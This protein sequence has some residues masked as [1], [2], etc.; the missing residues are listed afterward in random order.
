MNTSDA[1]LEVFDTTSAVPAWIGSIPVGIDPV[2]V[3]A[4][5]ATEA[6]VV[7]HISDSISVVDLNTMTV[8]R[9]IETED[10]PCDVVFAGTPERAFV[11]CSQ[12][13]LVQVF[14]PAN[15]V[16]P[17]AQLPILGEDPRAMAVSPDGS[18]VYVAIFESGNSSTLLGGGIEV[19]TILNFPPNVVNHPSG[20]YGG[21]NPP[22]NSGSGFEPP[23][24]PGL[25]PPPGVG[26][27]VKKD[28]SGLWRDDNGTDWTEFVSGS[29]AA[30]S[31]RPLGWDIPDRDVAVI[32]ANSLSVSYV[33]R[34]M[35]ACMAVCVNPATGM[36]TVV[37]T[38][39]INEVR[40]E[41]NVAGRFVRVQAAMIDPASPE[42]PTIVDL[43]P[44]LD[45]S[46]ERVPMAVRRRSIG[47]PRSIVWRGDGS[48]GYVAGMGSNN[49]IVIDAAGVRSGLSDTI[50]VGSGPAGLALDEARSV[51]YVLNRFEGSV[52]GVD[53]ASE[54]EVFRVSFFDPTPPVVRR[55]RVHLY[56]THST[57]GLGH[58][59]CASCHIDARFDRLAWDLGNPAGH[60]DPLTN[61][62]LGAGIPGL[63]PQTAPLPFLPH[64]PMKGPMTTQTLQ[65]IIGMEPHHWR[66][67]RD[68]LEAFN[69]AFVGLNGADVPLNQFE[70]QDFEDFLATVQFPPNPFRNSDNS[71]PT[72]LPL[73]G[74]YTPGR[75]A[76]P[77]QP[78]PNGNAVA[79]RDLYRST[80]R[81]LDQGAFACVT[82]HTL[83]TGAGPD[84]TWQGSQFVPL[85][86]GPLGERHLA[87]VSVDGTTNRSTKI[88]HL[89]N[90]HEKVGMEMTK[91]E[92]LAGFGFLHDGSI[93]SL[94]RFVAQ[95]AFNV[96]ND[97]EIA[98]LIAFMLCLSGS[99]LPPGTPTNPLVPPGPPS[100]DTHAAV[101]MQTTVAGPGD[102]NNIMKMN[103]LLSLADGSPRISLIA[104]GMLSGEARGWYY[105]GAGQFQSDR[106]AQQHT[107]GDLV[108]LSHAGGGELTLT[109]VVAGSAVRLGV[110]R[111]RDGWLDRDELDVCTDPAD[112]GTYPGGPGSPDVNGEL[113]INTLD[114]IAFLN[115]FVV[116]DPLADFNRDGLVNTIDFIA[117]LNAWSAECF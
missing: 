33:H 72:N 93:D 16:S 26:L 66:G 80:V 117:F 11:T 30:L 108:V 14:D 38:D 43:N 71:L 8:S 31:G 83:P 29:S 9:T 25:P 97:Q 82:C 2:T 102:V 20:P 21:I 96:V 15:P 1:R 49:I 5:T 37:G 109:V 46:S 48:L 68:G 27:I 13:N 51:L 98:N 3:R 70:M 44:H 32:D 104:K 100:L 40:F 94:A 65:H 52:S 56:D 95:P 7:N 35:N 61:R 64:H 53:L 24:N 10:E 42:A 22:P 116:A 111:D 74:H 78:L 62:N 115:A 106:A 87:L 113:A 17:L 75:F 107:A 28:A 105:L 92:S 114:V 54:S 18:T 41:P 69:P 63:T 59:S 19:F 88:P 85:P 77:G 79:G 12:V 103:H 34:L 73:P 50:P 76:P 112:A 91:T 89:R 47:D 84:M 60:L 86:P 6:W 58:A 81:R 57:S 67:D 39:A 90:L 101:G 55:G 45:Y 36:V 23:L 4:R 110:D 99:D